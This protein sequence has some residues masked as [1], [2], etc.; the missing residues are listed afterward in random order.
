M[1]IHPALGD[2][3]VAAC[4]FADGLAALPLQCW[5]DVGR[6]LMANDPIAARRQLAVAVLGATI[7]DRRL[8]VDAWYAR[9]AVQ[10]A[11]YL[12]RLGTPAVSVLERRR[13]SAACAAA[14][15]AAVALVA[16]TD[17]PNDDFALLIAPFEIVADRPA[18]MLVVARSGGRPLLPAARGR[19]LMP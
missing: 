14:S 8:A 15:E 11:A 7:A 17:L 16:R 12:A 13:F 3:I 2:G 1:L 18:P 10:T 9:D 19:Y 4:D 6:D 5:L